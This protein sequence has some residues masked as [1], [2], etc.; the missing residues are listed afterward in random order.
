MNG[1]RTMARTRDDW[2]APP[3]QKKKKKKPSSFA[4]SFPTTRRRPRPRLSVSLEPRSLREKSMDRSSTD[5]GG[6]K[7]SFGAGEEEVSGSREASP[8]TLPARDPISC[9]RLVKAW[10][11]WAVGRIHF[12]GSHGSVGIAQMSLL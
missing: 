6:A 10:A 3:R 12:A 9:V 5:S 4:L 1:S 8:F 11:S 2:R 7:G